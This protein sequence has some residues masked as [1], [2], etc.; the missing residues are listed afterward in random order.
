MDE[1]ELSYVNKYKNRIKHLA[2]IFMIFIIIMGLG[3][4]ALGTYMIVISEA[5]IALI[6]VGGILIVMGISDIPLGIYFR[7]RVK[8][9]ITKMD[10]EEALKR[11]KRIYGKI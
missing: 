6:F 10:D 4:I 3:I 8:K 2:L 11:Y 7:I 9:N 1:L 5:N